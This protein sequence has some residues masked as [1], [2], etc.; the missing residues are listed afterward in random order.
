MTVH[1]LI[2]NHSHNFSKT[3]LKEELSQ[4]NGL[5]TLAQTTKV[6][7][8]S[9]ITHGH[10]ILA[11]GP[12]IIPWDRRDGGKPRRCVLVSLGTRMYHTNQQRVT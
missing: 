3:L 5:Y 2:I 7:W 10:N 4:T 11:T 6:Y 12:I 9:I 8:G 1:S